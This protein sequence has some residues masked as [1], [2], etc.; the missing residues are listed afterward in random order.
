MGRLSLT[1]L[2]STFVTFVAI[3]TAKPSETPLPR[4][5]QTLQAP[6]RIENSDR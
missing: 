5:L 1:E 4:H 2:D 6:E 3:L